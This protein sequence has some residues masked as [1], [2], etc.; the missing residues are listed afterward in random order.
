MF[1]ALI[2][3]ARVL[4]ILGADA[5]ADG[6]AVGALRVGLLGSLWELDLYQPRRAAGA[7]A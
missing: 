4:P 7:R 5:I 3:W 2:D 1:G 6:V